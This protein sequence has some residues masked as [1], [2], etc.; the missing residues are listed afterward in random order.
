MIDQ[1]PCDDPPLSA[2]EKQFIG[3]LSLEFLARIDEALLA[4]CTNDWRKVAFVVGMTMLRIKYKAPDVPD[5][6]FAQRVI[7]LVEKGLLE[8]RGNLRRM[9]FSEVRIP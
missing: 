2:E 8:S 3:A 6:Y 9:R 1:D 5:M 7:Q 4:N